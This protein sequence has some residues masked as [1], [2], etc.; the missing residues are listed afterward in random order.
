MKWIKTNDRLPEF[1]FPV[2]VYCR[3][4]GRFIATYEK[5]DPDFNFGN[6]RRNNELGILPPLF[7]MYLPEPP[8]L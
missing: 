1:N 6:W 2:L 4:Y 5:L 3:I 8:Q 7:W